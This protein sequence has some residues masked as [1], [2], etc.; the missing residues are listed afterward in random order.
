[1]NSDYKS[2]L[3]CVLDNVIIYHSNFF[4]TNSIVVHY[5]MA[6]LNHQNDKVKMKA[7]NSAVI[8]N[9]YTLRHL[10]VCDNNKSDENLC[11]NRC[12]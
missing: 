8:H 5:D 11:Q 9:A 2:I 7:V 10:E 12:Q 1:M 4:Y 3:F 6:F